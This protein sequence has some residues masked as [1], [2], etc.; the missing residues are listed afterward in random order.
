MFVEDVVDVTVKVTLARCSVVG[1]PVPVDD[2]LLYQSAL[3]RRRTAWSCAI[4]KR[5]TAEDLASVGKWPHLLVI[6]RTLYNTLS[7]LD[8]LT[9]LEKTS[10]CLSS[11]SDLDQ[12]SKVPVT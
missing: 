8:S 3:V 7:S 1:S 10:P 12:L 4:S 11:L 5:T 6:P 2:K 9:V